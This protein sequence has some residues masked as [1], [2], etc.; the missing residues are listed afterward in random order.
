MESLL[1]AESWVA[2]SAT[3]FVLASLQSQHYSGSGK[4]ELN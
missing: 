1:A 3:R 4:E 2:C